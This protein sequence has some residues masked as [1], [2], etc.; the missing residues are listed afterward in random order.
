MYSVSTKQNGIFMAYSQR[1]PSLLM[2]ASQCIIMT[3]ISL[4]CNKILYLSRVNPDPFW[5]WAGTKQP[6]SEESVKYHVIVDLADDLMI[7]IV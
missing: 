1:L 5:G 3:V 7:H 2:A 6:S 4:F